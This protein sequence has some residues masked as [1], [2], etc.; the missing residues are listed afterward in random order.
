VTQAVADYAKQ[1]GFDVIVMGTQGETNDEYWLV[2]S[3]TEKMVRYAACPVLSVRRVPKVFDLK[4]IVLACD[5]DDKKT[6]PIEKVKEIQQLFGAQLNLIY[7]NTPS[8]FSPTHLVRHQVSAFAKKYDLQ[9]YTF[10]LYC[11]YTEDDGINHFAESIA[12]DMIVMI[13]H[14]K[15]GI[16]RLL[17]G[18]VSE[19]VVYEAVIPVLTIGIL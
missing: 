5:L 1:G 15:R 11:D 4:N 3:N 14:Q 9:N 10:H 8:S 16:A 18:S 2:G 7:I 6:L 17:S 12:A 13:S 19:G